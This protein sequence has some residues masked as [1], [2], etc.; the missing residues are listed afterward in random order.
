MVA[1]SLIS[2]GNP[3]AFE[4]QQDGTLYARQANISGHVHAS[5]GTLNNVTINENCLILGK[6]TAMQIVGDIAK[7]IYF[8]TPSVIKIEPAPFNRIICT[9]QIVVHADA[10]DMDT[11]SRYSISTNSRVIG[12]N[13]VERGKKLFEVSVSASPNSSRTASSVWYYKLPAHT[14]LTLHSSGKDGYPNAINLFILKD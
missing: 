11:T 7:V 13:V 3:P 14:E 2:S 5:S 8:P 4:L 12:G 10:K 1:G 9:P 6:L